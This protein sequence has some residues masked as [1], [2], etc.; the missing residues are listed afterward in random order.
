MDSEAQ[1][2][3][4][5][6]VF[7]KSGRTAPEVRSQ[8]FVFLVLGYPS[9]LAWQQTQMTCCLS[10]KRV[11]LP[12]KHDV[13]FNIHIKLC[14]A[15]KKSAGE[16]P[17]KKWISKFQVD[18]NPWNFVE[19]PGHS[20]GTNKDS[21]ETSCSSAGSAEAVSFQRLSLRSRVPFVAGGFIYFMEN[22]NRKYRKWMRPGEKKTCV[23]TPPFEQCSIS[24]YH[25][26]KYCLVDRD[27]RI[28]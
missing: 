17:L 28:G 20:L 9:F 27:S 4:Q 3:W 19:I 23:W 8:T 1:E 25:S 6:Q 16:I 21:W 11:V 2:I 14:T 22:P 5:S 24:L 15:P 13:R 7:Q 26:M 10:K 12:T 18:G